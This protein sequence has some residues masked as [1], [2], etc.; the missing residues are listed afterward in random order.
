MDRSNSRGHGRRVSV[1]VITGAAGP[2]GSRVRALLEADPDVERVVALDQAAPPSNGT[3]APWQRADLLA[4]D[5]EPWFG[6][7]DT[8]VHLA[9]VFGP[10]LDGDMSVERGLEVDL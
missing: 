2:L 5:L 1:V 9:S 7:A 6:G 8:V 3:A 10:D 4:A